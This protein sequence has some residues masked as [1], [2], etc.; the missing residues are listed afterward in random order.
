MNCGIG[1]R[2]SS[3]TA[4]LWLWCRLAA[5]ALI[6]PLA[7]EPPYA[8]GAALKK[9][10]TK[11]NK[12]IKNTV[13]SKFWRP[14][15]SSWGFRREAVACLLQLLVAA[16]ASLAASLQP[17]PPS[18]QGLLFCVSTSSPLLSFVRMLVTGFKSHPGNP[19]WFHSKI[20][21]LIMSAKTIFPPQISS[22][23]YIL[24]I[25]IWT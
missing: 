1:H 4:L 25:R 3:D 21:S 5:T 19:G 11:Q 15:R 13:F 24:A 10:K 7:W 9:V 22:H 17:L 8:T 18:S 14:K 16:W 23:A 6:W 20:S 12:K 2:H